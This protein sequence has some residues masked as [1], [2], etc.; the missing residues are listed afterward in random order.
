MLGINDDFARLAVMHSDEME[1]QPS[2]SPDVWRKRLEHSGGV[3]SGRVTS[4][5][6][7]GAGSRFAAHRHPEGEEFFVLEGTFCDE[8]GEYPS[9]TF[10]LNPDGSAHAPFSPD[11]CVLFV[12]LR[13]YPGIGRRRVVIDTRQAAWQAHAHA[14]V[15]VL[16]LY[17]EPG[18]AEEI[19]LVRLASGVDIAP[20]AFPDGEEILVLDGEFADEHGAYRKGSWVRYPRGSQHAPRSATG[21]T[22]YVKKGHLV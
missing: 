11:G 19:H 18:Y 17:Q 9:G 16:P 1:F 21:C 13:Q 2:P 8:D 5:V 4:I 20:V 12:K 22:L 6:R 10:V 14:G 7:Y 15:T 3:E